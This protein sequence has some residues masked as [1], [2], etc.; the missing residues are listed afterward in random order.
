M[1]K[2]LLR[3]KR[4]KENLRKWLFMY[5]GVM[6]LLTTVIT[7]SKYIS[8]LQIDDDARTSKFSFAIKEVNCS[9][10]I[11]D[12]NTCDAKS[13]EKC[14]PTQVITSCFKVDTS[15][16]EVDSDLYLTFDPALN[17]SKKDLTTDGYYTP[18]LKNINPNTDMMVNIAGVDII[19]G[20]I[21]TGIYPT[22]SNGWSSSM[23]SN[24]RLR[25]DKEVS[26]SEGAIWVFRVRMNKVNESNTFTSD[27]DSTKLV[28]VGYSM[29]QITT[30]NN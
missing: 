2:G 4:F 8:S 20:G 23:S 5:T 6:L 12:D 13:G 7:Y 21:A 22:A 26:A 9:D 3:S 28:K 19:S 29:E 27:S 25:L 16:L 30:T 24:P 1:M 14:R 18:N 15:G 10:Y 11:S 17:E